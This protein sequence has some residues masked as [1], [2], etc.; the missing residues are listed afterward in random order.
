MLAVSVQA[1]VLDKSWRE[2]VNNKDKAWFRSDMAKAIA[3][4]VILYQRNIGGW[5]KNVQMQK[6]LSDSQ[7]KELLKT[8]KKGLDCTIDNGATTMEMRYLSKMYEQV[9]DD[10]Y[11]EAFEK[12]LE[13]LIEA[14]Y[15]NGGWPQF[16]PLRKGYYSHITFNDDAMINVMKIL[17]D[18]S[19]QN[20]KLSIKPEGDLLEKS[21]AAF[22]KGISCILNTQYRQHGTLTAWCAQYD[23]ISL[24]PTKA[25]AYELPSLS[26]AESADIVLFLMSLRKPSPEIITSVEYAV[27]WLGKTKITGLKKVRYTTD[28]G[29]KEKKF[30]KDPHAPPL[31]ARFMELDDNTPFFC[32][33]DGIKKYSITEIGQERRNGY[34]WYTTGPQKALDRFSTW[35][36]KYHSASKGSPVQSR[37]VVVAKDGTGDF[38]KIQDAIDQCKSFPP[39]RLIIYVK[40]GTYKEKIKVHEWNTKISLIGESK[41]NTIITY[42]DYFDK[43]DKGRN[44]TFYTYTVLVEGD[45]FYAAN[46]TIE[47]SSG[48]VGQAVALSVFA[49]K[50]VVENCVLSGYQDTLYVSGNGNRQY[51]SNCFIEGSTDFV[52][53]GATS[54]F[55]NCV[56]HS[57]TDS[58]VTAASTPNEIPFGFVFID[59][60]LTADNE[61]TQVYLGRPWRPYAKTVFIHC[62]LGDH[63][64]PEGWHNWNKKQAENTS[65]YAEYGS[66]GEG[67]NILNR[68]DWSYQLTKEEAAQYTK[69]N[70]LGKDAWFN[71]YSN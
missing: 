21:Q 43:M 41:E 17:R 16:Y 53:G 2:I 45:E 56:I 57:K 37:T 1:Q 15:E 48:E 26:G 34:A 22:E 68:V 4:N 30:V 33:R 5:P 10:R 39:E 42:D 52:F 59:C 44:S 51:F 63:I 69:E 9:N 31:W 65:F 18:V 50:V 54:L 47:N 58:Y 61:V 32:D 11:R 70:I 23:E 12:G 62:E 38:N 7:K 25:R 40:N 66:Y 3:E 29:V 60:K 6:P 24:K 67:G 27:A 49:D 14:Q 20:D 55:E 36:L 19:Y 28:A 64:R 13:Y 35:K 46:L 71:T 8:K